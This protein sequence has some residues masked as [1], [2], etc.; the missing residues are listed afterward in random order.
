MGEILECFCRVFGDRRFDVDIR[1]SPQRQLRLPSLLQ[2]PDHLIDR[3]VQLIL[4][5]V[6]KIDLRRVPLKENVQY[7]FLTFLEHLPWYFYMQVYMRQLNSWNKHL[8]PN[9]IKNPISCINPSA[10]TK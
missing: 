2:G 6:L 9:I 4:F 3:F 8:V 5:R 1:P 10:S 7:Y